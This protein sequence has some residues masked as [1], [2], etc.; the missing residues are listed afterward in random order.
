MPKVKSIIRLIFVFIFGFC[1][2][3]ISAASTSADTLS[4]SGVNIPV[5]GPTGKWVLAPGSD[6]RCLTLAPD[7]TLYCCANP[8]GTTYRLFKSTDHGVSWSYT[9]RVEDT[10]LDIAVMP[11][12]PQQVYYATASRVYRSDDAGNSFRLIG[13][14]PGGAGTGGVEIT[15]M[16]VTSA[17]GVNH[18]IIGTRDND[19]LEIGGVYTLEENELEENESPTWSNAAAGNYDF[20]DVAFSPGFASDRQLVAIGTDER[21]TIITT[22][23]NNAG[24]NTAVGDARLT[25]ITAMAAAIAFPADYEAGVFDKYTQYVAVNSGTGNGNVF[26][27]EGLAGPIASRLTDLKAGTASGQTNLDIASLAV[28][29]NAAAAKIMVGTATEAHTYFSADGGSHWQTS[30]KPP[31]GESQTYVALASDF[32]AGGLAF[33]AT[34]GSESAFSVSRDQGQT[35]NQTG[36]IDTRITTVLDLAVSPDYNQDATLM[37]LTADQQNSLWRGTSAGQVWERVF[38]TTQSHPARIDQVLLSPQYSENTRILLSGTR[39]GSPVIWESR[40]GGSNFS[41]TLS[42]DPQTGAPV[43]IDTWATTPGDVLFAAGFDG[44]DAVVY[45]T[46]AGALGYVDKARCGNQPINSLAISPDFTND[47]AILAGNTNGG[48]FLSTDS[49]LIFEPL[50]AGGARLAGNVSVAF[51]R[52]Y[53]ENKT[54]YAGGDV[55]NAGIYRFRVGSSITWE[56]IDN[57]LPSGAKIGQLVIGPAGVL[58]AVNLQSVDT[59]RGQGGMERCLNPASTS[60]PVFETVTAGLSTGSVLKK[61]RVA[62]NNIWT[63]DAAQSTLLVFSDSLTTPIALSTPADHSPGLAIHNLDLTWET[64]AGATRYHWQVDTD[65]GFPGNP[66]ELEAETAA[67]SARIGTLDKDTTYYWRVN[68]SQPF[69]GPWSEVRSFNT[70]EIGIPTPSEPRFDSTA[71]VSPVFRWSNATGA[72]QYQLQLARNSDFADI[73]KDQTVGTNFWE[74]DSVLPYATHYYWRVKSINSHNQSAWSDVFIFTTIAMPTTP[75]SPGSSSTHSSS[76]SPSPSPL[77]APKL[78]EPKSTDQVSINPIFRWSVSTGALRYELVVST[79]DDFLFLAVDKTGDD[80][81]NANVWICLNDLEFNTS[82][83][84]KVRA[85]NDSSKGPW[86]EVSVFSTEAAPSPKASATPSLAVEKTPLPPPS[87]AP[88]PVAQRVI[89]SSTPPLPS[90]PPTS[91]STPGSATFPSPNIKPAATPSPQPVPAAAAGSSRTLVYALVGGLVVLTGILI[92]VIIYML[93]KFKR[94]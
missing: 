74:C 73:F 6:I 81:C 35:W 19:A 76:P 78:S 91:V 17:A 67:N 5:D 11:G 79:H 59:D 60:A 30:Q 3:G 26:R 57:T 41:P 34:S 38:G 90:V 56:S 64:A 85:V 75:A 54:V 9:G 55:A 70:N 50:P 83:Y 65:A 86:S 12:N 23:I 58:Y 28:G 69:T 1:L 84:W 61:L 63:I 29:G 18:V 53:S 2:L 10:I 24:W 31:S 89:V 14:C 80:A 20:V 43:N 22:N 32:A 49:G 87:P 72:T 68:A 47:R 77:P 71:S 42:V 40:N 4:W 37:M 36:L 46:S 16:D 44:N 27:L 25:G 92:G 21:D 33:A 39:E 52:A 62:G 66:E 13:D 88:S 45:Q 7:G 48:V 82:Y 51:D 94:Y 15:S 8:T 93:K